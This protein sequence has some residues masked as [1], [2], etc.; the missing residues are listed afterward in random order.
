MKS[1]L[2]EGATMKHAHFCT[3]CDS[4]RVDIPHWY[5]D[6]EGWG[7]VTIA[8]PVC[9]GKWT[10]DIAEWNERQLALAAPPSASAAGGDAT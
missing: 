2:P 6:V 4:G 1:E 7:T 5:E 10:L 3:V 8:C 9:G